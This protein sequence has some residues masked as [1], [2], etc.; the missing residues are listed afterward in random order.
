MPCTACRLKRMP[1]AAC[2]AD[3]GTGMPKAGS[4]AMYTGGLTMMIHEQKIDYPENSPVKVTFLSVRNYSPHYHFDTIEI[5]YCFRGKVTIVSGFETL[6]LSEGEYYTTSRR[7]IHSIRAASGTAEGADSA[8][9]AVSAAGTYSASDCEDN[10][11]ML[12][13]L[14]LT[15]SSVPYQYLK[16][17][18]FVFEAAGISDTSQSGACLSG[19]NIYLSRMNDILMMLGLITTGGVQDK[20][21][22]ISA[23]ELLSQTAD[24]LIDLLF[25]HFSYA[26]YAAQRPEIPENIREISLAMSGYIG[27][28]YTEKISLSTFAE[29]L[30]FSK[31]H[32]ASLM[33]NNLNLTFNESLNYMRCLQAEHLLLTTDKPNP[34]IS[35][36]CG[37]SDTKYFYANFKKWYGR[38]PLQHKEWYEELCKAPDDYEEIPPAQLRSFIEEYYCR[39]HSRKTIDYIIGKNA[40]ESAAE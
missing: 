35:N 18:L 36:E 15:A 21:L 28:H 22:H 40:P 19:P 26:N 29:S 17:V 5:I 23:D 3:A 11:I 16:S 33:K 6:T 39:Y 2:T 24:N 34:D 27:T 8:A 14:D 25:N 7:D 31:T 20:T 10:I 37:F 1:E 38:T 12:V 32:L 4:A 13:H 9:A 30:H